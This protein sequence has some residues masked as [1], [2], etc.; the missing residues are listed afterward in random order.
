MSGTKTPLLPCPFC[1]G[2]NINKGWET[3]GHGMSQDYI[4]CRDCQVR[5]PDYYGNPETKW[6]QRSAQPTN[7]K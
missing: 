2:A 6:N 4:E 5:M 3:C 1:G 7:P